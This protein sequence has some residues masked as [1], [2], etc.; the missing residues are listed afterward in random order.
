[1]QAPR[2]TFIKTHEDAKL[3]QRNNKEPLIGD[4]GYDIYAVEDAIIPANGTMTVPIGLELGYI[5]PGYWIKIE[6]R[7]GLFFKHGISAFA[8]V[9]DNC[10]PKGTKIYTNKGQINVENLL[11]CNDN[12]IYSFNEENREI[13]N[14]L[15]KDIWIVPNLELTSIVLEDET[16]LEIPETKRVFT[17]KGWVFVKELTEFDEIL[18]LE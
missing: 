13:E 5:E 10:V 16:V 8:G 9:V 15:I 4:S 18:S 2:I 3:P 1:M 7:S 11:D 6:S 17:K 12:H 14:D